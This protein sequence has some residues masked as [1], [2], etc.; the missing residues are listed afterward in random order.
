[1]NKNDLIKKVA[2]VLETKKDAHAAVDR[3]IEAITE[4]LAANYNVTLVGFG[5]FKAVKRQAKKGRNPK[6][7]EAVDIPAKTVPKFVPGKA[8]KEA[9]A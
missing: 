5:T 2:E 9:V 3:M 4:A 1:M 8:L 6:T 7:G